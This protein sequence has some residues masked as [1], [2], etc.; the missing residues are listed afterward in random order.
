[1][2]FSSTPQACGVGSHHPRDGG[3]AAVAISV[4][5]RESGNLPRLGEARD[6]AADVLEVVWTDL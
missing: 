1:M 3:A 6:L 4:A 2:A 5:V